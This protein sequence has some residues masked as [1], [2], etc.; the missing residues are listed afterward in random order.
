MVNTA[1]EALNKGKR[2]MLEDQ[3]MNISRMAKS[4]VQHMIS[5]VPIAAVNGERDVLVKYLLLKKEFSQ[6]WFEVNESD[7]PGTPPQAI[8]EIKKNRTW[9]E[10]R[11]FHTFVPIFA[12]IL[13][14]WYK[15][16]D[17]VT[18]MLIAIRSIGEKAQETDDIPVINLALKFFNTFCRS[19]LNAKDGT[20]LYNILYQYRLFAE[21]LLEKNEEISLRIVFFIKYYGE[22]AEDMGVPYVLETSIYDLMMLNYVAYEKKSRIKNAILDEFLSIGRLYKQTGNEKILRDFRKR[23]LML[24]GFYLLKADS[25][26]VS[27]ISE[28]LKEVPIDIMRKIEKELIEVNDPDF[29][30]ITDRIINF[31]YVGAAHKD[32]IRDLVSGLEL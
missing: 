19:A 13:N 17:V 28:V 21:A 10:M 32:K 22:V 27:K 23:C 25:E 2:K 29:W 31:D 26:F 1:I 4:S 6:G 3:I 18:S 12:L 24:G 7:F 9:L 16:R 14:S 5:E 20:I 15:L 8:V 11:T 30:E